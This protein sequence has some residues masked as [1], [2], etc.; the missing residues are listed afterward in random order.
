MILI[1]ESRIRVI[2]SGVHLGNAGLD[3]ISKLPSLWTRSHPCPAV[4]TAHKL[5]VLVWHPLTKEEDAPQQ[6]H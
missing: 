4:A 2:K 1:A 3:K 5:A 6:G